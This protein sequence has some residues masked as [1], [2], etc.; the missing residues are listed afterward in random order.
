MA[1]LRLLYYDLQNTEI[2]DLKFSSQVSF[3]EIYGDQLILTSD[4]IDGTKYLSYSISKGL[5]EIAIPV[6][7]KLLYADLTD[8]SSTYLYTLS[9]QLT[10]LKQDYNSNDS[11]TTLIDSNCSNFAF[12]EGVKISE[13]SSLDISYLPDGNYKIIG[14]DNQGHRY[15][16]QFM[17]LVK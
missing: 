9:D 7:A 10:V 17:K 4:D 5:Q 1:P 14:V 12:R 13:E 15:Q 3:F 11:N 2:V 6:N 8:I 16:S